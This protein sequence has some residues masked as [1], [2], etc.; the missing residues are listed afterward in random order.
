MEGFEEFRGFRGL[1]RE[2][3]GVRVVFGSLIGSF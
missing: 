3:S 1:R 2:G